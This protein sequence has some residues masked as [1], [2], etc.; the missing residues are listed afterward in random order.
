MPMVYS[1]ECTDR[2][3]A[4][5]GVYAERITALA[6]GVFFPLRLGTGLLTVATDCAGG[7][8]SS[9]CYSVRPD[10]LEEAHVSN[11]VVFI[12]MGAMEPCHIV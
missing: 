5:L 3:A 2:T 11:L 10:F 8:P 4:P 1:E 6:T 7:L 9:K 12:D